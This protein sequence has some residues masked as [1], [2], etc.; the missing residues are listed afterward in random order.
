[1]R[2]S[3]PVNVAVRDGRVYAV[4]GGGPQ[5]VNKRFGTLLRVGHDHRRILADI[6]GY[7]LTDPDPT[8]LDMPANPTESNP[9]GVAALKHGRVLVTD[10]AG[11]DL[12]LVKSNGHVADGRPVPERDHQ[13]ELAAG[14]V[15]RA[16]RA[17]VPGRG[18]ADVGRRRPGRVLVR[19]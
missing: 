19:R 4:V 7:Q 14:V 3:G 18:R 13:H 8:D 16:A 15:R 5:D 11:N 17:D 6:A 2:S 9:Y 10:A 1:M 12:L